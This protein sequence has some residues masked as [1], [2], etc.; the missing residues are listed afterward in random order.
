[1]TNSSADVELDPSVCYRHPDRQSWVL[2]QRCGRTVCPECQILAPVGVQCPDCVRETAG[3]VQWRP[4]G[5]TRP[6]KRRRTRAVAGRGS[7]RTRA[8]LDRGSGI[9][10]ATRTILA[11][12]VLLWLVGFVTPLPSML[13]SAEPGIE[14]Q[15]W[16]FVTAPFG[17]GA[18]LSFAGVFSFLLSVVFFVL[19]GPTLE[20]MLGVRRFLGVFVVSS[21]VGSACMLL[22]GGGSAGLTAPLFGLFAA[23]LVLVWSDQRTRTQILI[24]IAVN[25]LISIVAGG[26]ASLPELIG[27]MVGGA[28]TTYLYRTAADRPWKPRTPTL[29]VTASSVG[30]AVLAILRGLAAG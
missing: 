15:V 20:R 13:L 12:A 24:L 23:L 1:M 14:W 2:C 18:S 6:A 22:T 16:R 19:T 8:L 7:G 10:V 29:I 3:G 17:S 4:A 27:G 5:P 21:V 25:L 11:V 28:G 26:G 30:F 9:P